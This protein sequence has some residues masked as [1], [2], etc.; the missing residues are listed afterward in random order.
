M[1]DLRDRD[2]LVDT[3]KVGLLS[4]FL[5]KPILSPIKALLTMTVPNKLRKSSNVTRLRSKDQEELKD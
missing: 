1:E 3:V 2:A 4:I 5:S